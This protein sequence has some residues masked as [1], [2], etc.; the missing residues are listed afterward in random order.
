MATGFEKGT[1]GRH[2]RISD[3]GEWRRR[4]QFGRRRRPEVPNL[5]RRPRV[6]NLF[7]QVKEANAVREPRRR[8]QGAQAAAVR[9]PQRPKGKGGA[10]LPAAER[11]CREPRCP[12]GV[13]PTS[14]PAPRLA[15]PP[16]RHGPYDAPSRGLH[17]A[18]DAPSRGLRRSSRGPHGSMAMGS[19]ASTATNTTT[20]TAAAEGTLSGHR[21]RRSECRSCGTARSTACARERQRRGGGVGR[22]R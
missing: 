16:A 20:T 11:T 19:G 6:L 8:K 7:C 15:G 9:E 14:A 2:Q 17:G 12:K 1:G 13:C 18:Y 21:G 10:P 5:R 22:T 3:R 4:R